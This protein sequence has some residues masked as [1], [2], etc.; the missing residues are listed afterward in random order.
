MSLPKHPNTLQ[1]P[2]ID[3]PDIDLSKALRDHSDAEVEGEFSRIAYLQNDEVAILETSEPAYYEVRVTPMDHDEFWLSG[4]LDAKVMQECA[5]CLRPVAVELN[6]ELGTLLRFDPKVETP[7]LEQDDAGQE[8]W[9]FN[10][11][12]LEL[13]PYFAETLLIGLPMSILHDPKCK[14]L[15]MTCGQDLNEGTCE[16]NQA[17]KIV[18]LEQ[19][20]EAARKNPF[21]ALKGLDLPDE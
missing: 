10:N 15:C 20:E 5:R 6:L 14:G 19:L 11:S 3:Y 8:I 1:D 13:S 16:H 9:I 4:Q 21:A 2:T 17:V 18:P 12:N 7:F